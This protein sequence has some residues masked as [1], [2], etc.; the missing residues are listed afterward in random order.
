MKVKFLI[1]LSLL[2]CS[3][4]ATEEK[5]QKTNGTKFYSFFEIVDNKIADVGIG[6]REIEDTN[7]IDW[8]VAVCKPYKVRYHKQFYPV[9]LNL[10]YLYFFPKILCYTG[11]GI[12]MKADLN[13]NYFT[14]FSINPVVTFGFIS[15]IRNNGI[16]IELKSNFLKFIKLL[17]GQD[18]IYYEKSFKH[19]VLK[20]HYFSVNFGTYF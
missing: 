10:N 13:N 6:C 19:E 11:M 7:C 5:G 9:I 20:E 16:F 2:F 3:L 4:Q 18:Y 8:S 1:I 14:P 12:K 17:E 15:N